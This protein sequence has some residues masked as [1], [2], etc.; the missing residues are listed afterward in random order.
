MH[1]TLHYFLFIFSPDKIIHDVFCQF[2]STVYWNP[3]IFAYRKGC[4]YPVNHNI[5]DDVIKWNHFPRYW[6]F[7]RG[8]HRL[9]V[10]SPHKGQW[11]GALMFSLICARTKSWVNN[12]EAGDLRC[13]H[14]HYD[15]IVMI[16]QHQDD[17]VITN[18]NF[19][20]IFNV[21]F[22]LKLRLNSVDI[23]WVVFCVNLLSKKINL[24]NSNEKLPS[25]FKYKLLLSRQ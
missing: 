24:I 16:F 15:I 8:I 19:M 1:A 14:A 13:H 20:F 9:P 11:R 21:E 18:N 3:F 17:A 4:I 5:H 23:I 2:L 25:N 12:C 6:P 22:P 10:N 7:V